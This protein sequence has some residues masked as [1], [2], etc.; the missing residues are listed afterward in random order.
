MKC[1][2][3]CVLLTLVCILWSGVALAQQPSPADP[4]GIGNGKVGIG[5]SNPAD[6]LAVAGNAN[7][8]GSVTASSIALPTTTRYLAIPCAALM[9][10]SSTL[11]D[12]QRQRRNKTICRQFQWG[13][14]CPGFLD[15]SATA[16]NLAVAFVRIPY[17]VTSPLA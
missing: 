16:S 11:P 7:V 4:G 13:L 6:K 9:P 17:T 15:C 14:L 5:N 8:T 3:P 1:N 2:R 10:S 12:V